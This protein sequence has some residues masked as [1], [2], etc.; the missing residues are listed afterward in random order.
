[1]TIL[2]LVRLRGGSGAQLTDFIMS[3]QPKKAMSFSE[4]DS[5]VSWSH[6]FPSC[7]GCEFSLSSLFVFFRKKQKQKQ[8]TS[9]PQLG[10]LFHA[11]NSNS[12][13]TWQCPQVLL[14]VTRRVLPTSRG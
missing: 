1:M 4:A 11:S 6:S 5:P 12:E 13:D 8:K 14:A 10:Q 7:P 3:Y 2:I 9:V